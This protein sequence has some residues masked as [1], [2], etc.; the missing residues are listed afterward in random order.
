MKLDVTRPAEHRLG[1]D[2]PGVAMR[3]VQVRWILLVVAL[4][5]VPAAPAVA[6]PVAGAP[7]S[8]V[9]SVVADAPPARVGDTPTEHATIYTGGSAFVGASVELQVRL[10][11]SSTF[12]TVATATSGAGGALA[13]KLPPL[14]HNTS[15][16]WHFDGDLSHAATTSD[17]GVEPVSV[18]V[19]RHVSDRT[20]RVGQRVVV[21]GR[22]YPAKPGHA[23]SVWRGTKPFQGYGPATHHVRLVKG[24]V[25]A[26]G[27]YRL[28]VR[29]A[30]TGRVRIYVKVRGG[31]G[32]VTGFSKYRWLSVH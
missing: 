6:R 19:K 21:R 31:D 3:T 18:R 9:I 17:T 12:T 23:V 27:T 2:T 32:N 13:A 25:R 7:T 14:V 10:Y 5:M 20:P 16:R 26:D 30:S 29:F 8:I 15:Y 28:V 1:T 22:T 11:G 24:H 4:M